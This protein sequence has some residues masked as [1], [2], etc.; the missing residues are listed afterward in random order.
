MKITRVLEGERYTA[1]ADT[2]YM[3]GTASE[4]GFEIND[5]GT[6]F[7][8]SDAQLEA[9]IEERNREVQQEEDATETVPEPD[10]VAV[11]LLGSSTPHRRGE[12]GEHLE[13]ATAA[14]LDRHRFGA[15][16]GAS[17]PAAA[18]DTGR[19]PRCERVGSKGPCAFDCGSCHK[20]GTQ[21]LAGAIRV[22]TTESVWPTGRV[23]C[24]D[25]GTHA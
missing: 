20:C 21:I 12:R 19:C 25:C 2:G 7:W 8:V 24:M 15:I 14:A 18:A 1:A 10:A 22:F 9:A 13:L 11:G 23:Y 5:R 3:S 17:I 16:R 6:V 4:D